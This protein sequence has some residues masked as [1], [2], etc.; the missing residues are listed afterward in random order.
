MKKI[1][2]VLETQQLGL[3]MELVGQLWDHYGGQAMDRGDYALVEVFIRT[4]RSAL[5]IVAN[6][7]TRDFEGYPE[8]YSSLSVV[9]GALG[10]ASATAKGNL[11]YQYRGSLIKDVLVVRD[12]LQESFRGKP[13]FEL[14]SDAGVVF[15]LD[16]AYVGVCKGGYFTEDLFISTS[17]SLEDLRLYDGSGQWDADLD[18]QYESTRR[19]IPVTELLTPEIDEQ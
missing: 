8:D 17:K 6:R 18:Y 1:P 12:T 9:G 11:F 14:V 4:D 15:V 5:T 3:L 7:V 2:L 16:G 19:L 13:T 10:E